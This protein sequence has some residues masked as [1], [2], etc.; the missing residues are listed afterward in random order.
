MSENMRVW[1]QV[2]KT[3]PRFTKGFQRGG[4]FKGTS[5]NATYLAR[6]ATEM[7]GPAGE[8][9]GMEVIRE[10]IAEGHLIEVRDGCPVYAKTHIVHARLWYMV[11]DP[12]TGQK[13][14]CVGIEQFGQTE[15]VGKNSRG[16][17]TDEEAPKKSLTDAMVKCLSHLG[18]AAD[19]YLGLYDDNKYV[20]KLKEEFAQVESG[21]ATITEE[22]AEYIGKLIDESGA[23]RT[24]FLAAF[25]IEK[26]ADMPYDEYDNAVA[27]LNAKKAKKGN[28]A[29]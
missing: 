28:A 14:R 19:I 18:F 26:I 21:K 5:T 13:A 15:Y 2:S 1:D 24:K 10:Y 6:R 11:D 22:E 3:D 4:G 12:N 17:F 8:C 25:G 23:D 7:F 20:A 16:L 29:G 9:W 27:M